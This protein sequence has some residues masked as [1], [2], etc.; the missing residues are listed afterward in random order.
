MIRFWKFWVGLLSRQESGTSLALFRIAL[1]LCTLYSLLSIAGAGL[2]G[3]LWTHV[4]H[5]GMRA[6]DGNW[7]VK[8]LG[9]TT[10]GVVWSLWSLSLVSTI[11][12]TLGVG[13]S[14]LSRV[15][16]LI[17]VLAYN[18]LITINPYSSGG[19]DVLITNSFW[20]LFLAE[21]TATLS[22]ACHW[23]EGRFTSEREVS[24]WPRYVLIFQLLL[25]YTL[26]GLQKSAL[27]W[28]PAGGY[29]A[30]YWVM[31]DPTWMRFDGAFAAWISPLLRV[32]TALT[33]HWEQLSILLLLWFYYRTTREKGGRM[34]RW[35]LKRDWR[36]GWAL[37]GLGLHI[38][39]L[40]LMNVGPF[41]W[42][43]LSFYVLLWRPSEWAQAWQWWQARQAA[44][45]SVSAA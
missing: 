33:W 24:A 14:I 16:C 37:V 4:E 20:I 41:S 6:V 43:S 25:M 22:L 35:V 44:K 3:P 26:T 28:T 9:G 36:I 19:Y 10:P 18:G 5:G 15:N 42:V 29:T 34:R 39:I 1:G 27:V 17:L 12:F 13:G 45:K 31:Q 38:G 23:R 30:L 2:V 40:I 21:P 32:A 11:A 7:L 8:M